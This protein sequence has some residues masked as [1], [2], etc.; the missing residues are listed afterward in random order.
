MQMTEFGDGAVKDVIE[1][2]VGLSLTLMVSLKGKKL[3]IKSDTREA[4]AQRT[5][6]WERWPSSTKESSL[7]KTN[8]ANNLI[9]NL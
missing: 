5:E 6:A 8:P 4:Y 9:I 3:N 7:R 1:L 2:T